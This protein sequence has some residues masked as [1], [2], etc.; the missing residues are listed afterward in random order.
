MSNRF[1]R[2]QD[3][4]LR[5][6]QQ[7]RIEKEEAEKRARQLNNYNRITNEPDVSVKVREFALE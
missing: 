3:P 5:A 2:M 6:I 7:T 4:T 1:L